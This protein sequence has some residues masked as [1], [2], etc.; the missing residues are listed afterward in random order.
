MGIARR[1][2]SKLLQYSKVYIRIWQ[3]SELNIPNPDRQKKYIS[4]QEM[5]VL[6]SACDLQ[7]SLRC[8]NHTKHKSLEILDLPSFEVGFLSCTIMRVIE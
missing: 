7:I 5:P 2:Y 1:V 4:V 3:Y 6:C 8:V